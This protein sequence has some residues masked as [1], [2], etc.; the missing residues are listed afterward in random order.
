[1]NTS[2]NS[3]PQCTYKLFNYILSRKVRKLGSSIVFCDMNRIIVATKK[4]TIEDAHNYI[5]YIVNSITSQELFGCIGLQVCSRSI[6]GNWF[7]V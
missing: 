7:E 5:K 4:R 6:S 2:I 3:L 1:M